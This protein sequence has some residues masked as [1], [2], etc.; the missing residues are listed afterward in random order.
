MKQILTTLCAGLITLGTLTS[1]AQA[2]TNTN[3]PNASLFP[4]SRIA[5]E[6][7][8][9]QLDRDAAVKC[10]REIVE[11][12]KAVEVLLAEREQAK[13]TLALAKE[14]SEVRREIASKAVSE[15]EALR[16]SLT[17]KDGV[18]KDLRSEIETL[19]EK[20]NK[21]SPFKSATKALSIGATLY[22]TIRLLQ[23][24]F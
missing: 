11:Q 19:R 9:E 15:S 18:I 8:L 23:L 5:N 3:A 14:L 13:Q 20:R 6:T 16:A 12:R 17:V 21:K 1:Q 10:F 4:N 7:P 2:Q 22:G 24:I